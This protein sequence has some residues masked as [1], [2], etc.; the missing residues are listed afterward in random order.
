MYK[1]NKDMIRYR[2]NSIHHYT[3]YKSTWQNKTILYITYKIHRQI[4]TINTSN[5]DTY[6]I[7]YKTS[8]NVDSV[9]YIY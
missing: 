2:T 8:K 3:R 5:Y 1:Q 9:L 4:R 6:Y 7:I